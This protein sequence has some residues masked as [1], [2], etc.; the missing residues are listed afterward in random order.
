MINYQNDQ[1][2]IDALC[3]GAKESSK[4]ISWILKHAGWREAVGIQ[5]SKFQ[6]NSELREEVFYECL[7]ALVMNVQSKSFN[8]KSALKT[9]F[10]GICK[11]NLRSRLTKKTRDASRFVT[12]QTETIIQG[13]KVDV[14]DIEETERQSDI[15]RI[16]RDL[17]NK[18][19]DKCQKVLKYQMLDYSMREIGDLLGME[20]QSVKNR[21]LDCRKKLRKMTEGNSGLLTQIK[22]LI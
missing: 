5:L 7:S 9:Y 17:I 11:N 10:E 21:S 12:M 16:L 8:H 19:G 3:N 13:E 22:S 6:M 4:A 14:N 15:Q 1:E 20:R 2:L 18:L